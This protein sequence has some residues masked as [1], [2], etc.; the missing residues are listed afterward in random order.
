MNHCLETAHGCPSGRAGPVLCWVFNLLGVGS[1]QPWWW[2]PV[3]ELMATPQKDVWSCGVLLPTR[4]RPPMSDVAT[5]LKPTSILRGC[6]VYMVS[7][8]PVHFIR[9]VVM[10]GVAAAAFPDAPGGG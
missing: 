8:F 7:A 3:V 1:L 5:V 4:T 6:I 9:V 2:P 10:C